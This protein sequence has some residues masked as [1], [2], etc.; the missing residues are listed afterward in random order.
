MSTTDE[1][2]AGLFDFQ[3]PVV[4]TF[5]NLLEAKAVQRNGKATGD[6]KFSINIELDPATQPELVTAVKAKALET[7][8]AKWPGRDFAKEA[9][10]TYKDSEGVVNKKLPTFVFP[11]SSGTELA[12]NAKAKGKDREFSRGKLVLT[13]RSKFQPR[14]SAIVNGKLVEYGDET[15]IASGKAYFYNG[16]EAL[17]QVNFQAYDGV[18]ETGADG[19]TAYLN[20]VLSTNKGKKLSGQGASAAEV[21]GSYI[22]KIS[23][24]DPTAGAE[25]DDEISF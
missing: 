19:V 25:L 22:G 5:P 9:S 7:A 16:V 21:F 6:P 2:N 1:K 24:T 12:D 4:T 3:V 20:L 10:K 14:L 15:P 17:V 11:W 23:N 18:G 13:A 8:R